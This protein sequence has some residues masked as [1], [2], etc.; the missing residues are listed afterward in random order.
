[1]ID[2]TQ[3][4]NYIYITF[5]IPANSELGHYVIDL[6]AHSINLSAYMRTLLKKDMNGKN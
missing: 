4:P 3:K 5:A 6:Q 2:K 1:M